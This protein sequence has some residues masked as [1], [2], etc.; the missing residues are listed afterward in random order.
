MVSMR[1]KAQLYTP[2]GFNSDEKEKNDSELIL[3]ALFF[4][5]FL[6]AFSS[7]NLQA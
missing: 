2:K 6:F 3:W 1:F 5:S 7:S 4:F